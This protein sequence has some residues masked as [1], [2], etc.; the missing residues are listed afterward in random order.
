MKSAY[1]QLSTSRSE[2][3]CKAAIICVYDPDNGIP[4]FFLQYATP[5]GSVSSVYM[6]NRAARGLWAVGIWLG[7]AWTNYF[8]DYPMAE[9]IKSTF[10]ADLTVRSMF[11]LLGWT[12]ALEPKKN[13]PFSTKFPMLGVVANLENLPEKRAVYENKEERI[14]EISR[15][16]DLSLIHISEPTRPY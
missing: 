2:S 12:I 6:F 15:T 3:N 13:R 4:A 8:D 14:L 10:A 5:F 9:P 16:L 1:R 7:F 11:A